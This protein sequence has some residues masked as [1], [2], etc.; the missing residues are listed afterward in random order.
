MA[1]SWGLAYFLEALFILASD[2]AVK[3]VNLIL[4][5]VFLLEIGENRR[6]QP[7]IHKMFTS[8]EVITIEIE[9]PVSLNFSLRYLNSSTKATQV[10]NQLVRISEGFGS[11]RKRSSNRYHTPSGEEANKAEPVADS[12]PEL[13][14]RSQKRRIR[15]V[16]LNATAATTAEQKN[17]P[18]VETSAE[19]EVIDPL[20]E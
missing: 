4:I 17:K 11:K 6:L 20:K 1:G 19:I 8:K 5:H 18:Q 2:C 14:S 7:I 3:E 13:E 16:K 12:K 9:E 15:R 10:T